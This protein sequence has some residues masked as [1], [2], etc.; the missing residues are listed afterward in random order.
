MQSY[1]LRSLGTPFLHH[2]HFLLLTL[3]LQP[4]SN[5]LPLHQ[6]P[7]LFCSGHQGPTLGD[8]LRLFFILTFLV[9]WASFNSVTTSSPC[10][11]LVTLHSP[12]ALSSCPAVPPQDFF[13]VPLAL[14]QLLLLEDHWPSVGFLLFSVYTLTKAW[15]SNFSQCWSVSSEELLLR[16]PFQCMAN[17]FQTGHAQKESGLPFSHSPP[18]DLIHPLP[19]HTIAHSVNNAWNLGIIL[20]YYFSSAFTTSQPAIPVN[21]S[22]KRVSCT[23]THFL[24]LHHR[25]WS[26]Y[27]HPSP[28]VRQWPPS[29]V[30][31]FFPWLPYD[32]FL[33]SGQNYNHTTTPPTQNS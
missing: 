21:S 30:L 22:S 15:S 3:S 1:L 12:C 5:C 17:R 32:S 10:V 6:S 25:T 27:Q 2:Q 20:E 18:R 31:S 8:A 9:F 16:I 24:H 13:L 28:R 26:N 23:S 33:P 7:K 11:A 14:L 4:L 19:S 29:S